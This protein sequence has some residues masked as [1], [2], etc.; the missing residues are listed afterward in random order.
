MA[1]VAVAEAE[2][3]RGEGEKSGRGAQAIKREVKSAAQ[4]LASFLVM[5]SAALELFEAKRC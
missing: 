1:E 5:V 3:A 2:A 4:D